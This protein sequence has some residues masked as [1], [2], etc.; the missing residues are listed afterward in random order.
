MDTPLTV[1]TERV[2]DIPLLLAQLQRMDVQPLLD[3][4]F[5]TH[6][7]WQGLSLG[8]VTVVWLSHILSQADH[9]LNPVQAWVERHQEALALG[10]QQPVRALDLSDDRLESVLRYLSDDAQWRLFEPA[11]NQRQIQVY[12]LHPKRLRLDST[13][14]SADWTVSEAGLF[15]YGHSKDH[16]PDLPQLKLM[17][18]TLDP[19]GLPIATEIVPGQKADDPLYI[20]AIQQVRQTL[21]QSGLL[22]A[23]DSKMASLKTRCFLQ[24]TGDYYLCPLGGAQLKAETMQAYLDPVEQG[25]VELQEIH[26]DYADGHTA[27]I[28]KGYEQTQAC[29]GEWDGHPWTWSER[30]LVVYSLVYAQSAQQAFQTRLGQAQTALT[31]LNQ[32]GRGHTAFPNED[33]LT[34][35]VEVILTRYRVKDYVHLTYSQL[36]EQHTVRRYQ[37]R[38]ARVV[39]HRQF[40]VNY[41]LDTEAIGYVIHLRYP[42]YAWFWRGIGRTEVGHL[43]HQSGLQLLW[44]GWRGLRRGNPIEQ[45]QYQRHG[46]ARGARSQQYTQSIEVMP[47]NPLRL[48]HILRFLMESLHPRHLTPFFGHFDAIAHIHPLPLQAVD[49]GMLAQ[50]LSPVR[51]EYRH[52][53]R[54]RFKPMQ[55][56]LII[57]FTKAYGIDIARHR[58]GLR[59]QQDTPH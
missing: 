36:A 15:Q 44:L 12:D 41:T 25:T 35:A 28:A 43:R 20:P 22:Y 50:P 49:V 48:A 13:S 47:P 52:A 9:R 19:L 46:K 18:A 45:S 33:A 29:T 23:G 5:P 30:Q 3:D 57:P 16:R 37:D 10:L 38:P 55:R 8:Q 4:Y 34:Q 11:L 53:K 27:L 21:S 31:A 6:G 54:T 2:D 17:L 24:A 42:D 56:L 59:I 39:E 26:Y 7:N 14:V 51:T 40:Q 32:S 58:W 1:I